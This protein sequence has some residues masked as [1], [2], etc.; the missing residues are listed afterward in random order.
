MAEF[1]AVSN[2]NE[3][4]MNSI[5]KKCKFKPCI[6]SSYVVMTFCYVCTIFA[7]DACF[8]LTPDLASDASLAF[9]YCCN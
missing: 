8:Q 3:N 5:Q 7:L 6:K 9:F 2:R 4:D 1:I